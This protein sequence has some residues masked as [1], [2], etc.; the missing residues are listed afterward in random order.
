[1]SAKEQGV[2]GGIIDE[3]EET[4]IALILGAM[5]L[6]T[7]TNVVTRYIFNSN[8]LWALEA[9]VFMFAWLVLLG[10]LLVVQYLNFDTVLQKPTLDNR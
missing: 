9:S 2:I 4:L 1:M 6:L 10:A 3:I 5:T 7:F 8:I